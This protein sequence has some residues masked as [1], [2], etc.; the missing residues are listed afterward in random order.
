M[1]TYGPWI[2]RPNATA[3]Q[4]LE[5]YGTSGWIWRSIVDQGGIDRTGLVTVADSV[6]YSIGRQEAETFRPH[7]HRGGLAGSPFGK[8]AETLSVAQSGIGT[9]DANYNGSGNYV[10]N[11]QQNAPDSLSFVNEVQFMSVVPAAL[12][13]DGLDDIWPPPDDAYDVEIHPDDE[14]DFEDGIG[15]NSLYLR[16]RAEVLDAWMSVTWNPTASETTD[17]GSSRGAPHPAILANPFEFAAVEPSSFAAGRHPVAGFTNVG[18]GAGPSPSGTL[19]GSFY[20]PAPDLGDMD[21]PVFSATLEFPSLS[22]RSEIITAS[23]FGAAGLGWRLAWP[24]D[25]AFAG[26]FL[27]GAVDNERF[28]P[29]AFSFS[30]NIVFR[31]PRYRY[32]YDTEPRSRYQRIHPRHDGHGVSTGRILSG[33][34]RQRS[35]RIVGGSTYL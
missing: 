8:F 18:D 13:S 30:T 34:S 27:P 4:Y 32:V 17:N 19:L 14:Y 9:V 35:N 22:T 1:P 11:M 20:E 10:Y 25:A 12:Q 3:F 2:Q 6:L 29:T 16:D 31:P 15:F 33:K 21:R 24:S 28:D 26:F 7:V 23:G 5:R